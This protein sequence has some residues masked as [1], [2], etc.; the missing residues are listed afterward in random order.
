M[1][2]RKEIVAIDE[3]M[4][5]NGMFNTFR[6]PSLSEAETIGDIQYMDA[7]C[8]KYIAKPRNLIYYF[9]HPHVLVDDIHYCGWN[10]GFCR[11]LFKIKL[12]YFYL[13]KQI[14]G[15]KQR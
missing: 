7:N 9:R 3:N 14:K 15:R 13:Y 12:P 2:H 11:R 5:I 6:K 8:L 10:T 1:L 4:V